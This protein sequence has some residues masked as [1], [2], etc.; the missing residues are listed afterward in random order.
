MHCRAEINSK[1]MFLACEIF[2]PDGIS[3]SILEKEGPRFYDFFTR[4]NSF[5]TDSSNFVLQEEE[6]WEVLET[7]I[8][9]RAHAAI[10]SVSFQ[11]LIPGNIFGSAIFWSRQYLLVAFIWRWIYIYIYMLTGA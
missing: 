1:T 6:A 9:E 3:E 8:P 2:C 4:I 5:Q 7:R 11:K 10:K